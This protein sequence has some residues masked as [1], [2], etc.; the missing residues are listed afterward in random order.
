MPLSLVGRF[1]SWSGI[2]KL[3]SVIF[4]VIILMAAIAAIFEYIGIH[5]E[6]EKIKLRAA[7]PP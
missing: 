1:S 3:A 2:K 5:P 7:T 4:S 6:D